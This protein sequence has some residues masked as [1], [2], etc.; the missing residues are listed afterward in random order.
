[1]NEKKNKLIELA[2]QYLTFALLVIM[3]FRFPSDPDMGWHIRNGQDIIDNFGVIKEDIYSW[4]MSGYPWIAHEWLTDVLMAFIHSVAGLWGLVIFFAII[5]VGAFYLA[6]S[7]L[8]KN[9]LMRSLVAIIALLVSWN[10]I[11]IRPQMLTLLG[12]AVVLYI[13]FTCR[14]QQKLR[15]IYW[16]PPLFMLWANMHGGFAAG[17]VVM[18][19]FIAGEFIRQ[20]LLGKPSKRIPKDIQPIIKFKPLIIVGIVSFLATFINPYGWRIYQ[21]LF[22]TYED[23]AILNSISEWL[24][25]NLL[26]NTGYNI[27]VLGILLIVLLIANRWRVDITK[28]IIA[29]VMFF[30]GISSWRHMPLFAI[31]A[32]PLLAEQF[33]LLIDEGLSEIAKKITTPLII[34]LLFLVVGYN[35]FNSSISALSSPENF[36]YVANAPYGPVEYLHDN[37]KDRKM[38]NEYNIGGYLVW[39]LP[40]VKVFIDGRMAI[41]KRDDVEIFWEFKKILG[42]DRESVMEGIKEWS[43]DTILTSTTHPIGLFL[44]NSDDWVRVYNDNLYMIWEKNIVELQ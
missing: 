21:E 11:G 23:T 7:I 38:L 33:N 30:I 34:T 17:F 42:S 19:L 10:I 35:Y 22:Q 31:A 1:M 27:A 25:V 8:T 12:L 15:I 32:I 18:I 2:S 24:S 41:W 3:S 9:V 14:D 16:L 36:A 44:F 40:E 4:T 37:P 43:V 26:Q 5:I 39:Q 6:S 20:I 29:T 13:L 28:F